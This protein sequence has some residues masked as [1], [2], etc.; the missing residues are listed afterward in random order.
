MFDDGADGCKDACLRIQFLQQ[1]VGALVYGEKYDDVASVEYIVE[2][3][4]AG[5]LWVTMVIDGLGLLVF[6]KFEGDS[7]IVRG[8]YQYVAVLELTL[9]QFFGVQELFDIGSQ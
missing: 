2:H 4:L 9:Q 7:G 3:F 5:A 6:K 8:V 1:G